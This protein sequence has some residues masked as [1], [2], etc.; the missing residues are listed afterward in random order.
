MPMPVLRHA[1]TARPPEGVI[2]MLPGLGGSPEDFE[3][4]GFVDLVRVANPGFDVVVPDAHFG[5][6]RTRTLVQR[7]QADVFAAGRPE[8][9]QTWLLGTSMGGFGA[10]VYAMEHEEAID[11]LIL[12]APYLGPADIIEELRDAGG[13][14]A[15][16]PPDG[17]REL[18]DQER[19]DSYELWHWLRGYADPSNTR[20]RLFL[21]FGADDSLSVPGKLLASVLPAE[22][23][24]VIP[25]GHALLVW[26]PIL[27]TLL[28]RAIGVQATRVAGADEPAPAPR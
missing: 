14:A 28:P 8:S 6:Y 2:V 9:G 11:G 5:Y 24:Q 21:G 13:L 16:S 17:W 22:Q 7:L 27:A 23:T 15:W 19:R 10:V 3:H 26:R 20:P 18:E 12:L 1:A 25:G 4:Y